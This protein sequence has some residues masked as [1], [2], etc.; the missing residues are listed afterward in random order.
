M[1][2]FSL[3][4]LTAVGTVVVVGVAIVAA[5]KA[6]DC[7]SETQCL[8]DFP[9]F[10]L[11]ARFWG[12]FVRERAPGVRRIVMFPAAAPFFAQQQGRLLREALPETV[13]VVVWPETYEEWEPLRRDAQGLDAAQV[14][15]LQGMCR[16]GEAPDL[17]LMYLCGPCEALYAQLQGL[18]ADHGV[19]FVLRFD[20][21]SRPVD[22]TAVAMH[23]Q[24]GWLL[25]CA[26]P[27]LTVD[28]AGALTEPIDADATEAEVIRRFLRAFDVVCAGGAFPTQP[29]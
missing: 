14:T 26:V 3:T 24:E 12:A 7:H 22:E 23:L 1:R 9:D 27:R 8:V 18:Y 29:L 19:R 2:K 25:A 5:R 6:A 10:H 4:I 28:A 11:Q 21:G 15:V 16:D 13:D 17:V 20:C